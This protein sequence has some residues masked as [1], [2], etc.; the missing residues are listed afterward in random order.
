[1]HLECD[2]GS[3]ASL[4]AMCAFGSNWAGSFVFNVL[5]D[6][7][8]RLKISQIG[9]ILSLA[10]Y[11][12]YLPPIIYPL[13]IVYMLL[14]GF[15]NAYFLQS[16]I[17][18]VEFTSSENRDFYTIIAQSFDGLMGTFTVIVFS[19]TRHYKVFVICGFVFGFLVM[20]LMFLFVPES[21]R[22]YV[23]TNQTK[24]AL[25]VYKYLSQLHPDNNVKLKIHNLESRVKQGMD[26][27]DDVS[28]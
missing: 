23:A 11:L 26:L 10:L 25:G 28:E 7:Y 4:L 17:L 5:G 12:L 6:K 21:P 16:Y 2:D 27:Q 3:K 22:Y 9:F 19:L 15:L 20:I 24:K 18:G 13:L 14:F 8:G 1:M